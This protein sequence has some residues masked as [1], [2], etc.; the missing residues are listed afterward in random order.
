MTREF[1]NI[2]ADV[3]FEVKEKG[4]DRTRLKIWIDGIIRSEIDVPNEYID[5]PEPD[6]AVGDT[7][8]LKGVGNVE[9]DEIGIGN[10]KV[11]VSHWVDRDDLIP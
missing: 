4:A 1:V 7:M 5:W 9:V 3:E 11:L 2:N 10:K 8:M 6:F